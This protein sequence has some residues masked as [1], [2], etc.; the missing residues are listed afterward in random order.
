[1]IY[2]V[3]GMHK[4]GTTLVSQI[5]H[6]SGINMGEFDENVHYDKGNKYE[7]ESSFQLDLDLLGTSSDKVLDLAGGEIPPLSDTQRQRMQAVI[8]EGAATGGDWGMKDPRMCLTYERWREE[9]P[10]HKIIFVFRD[11]AQVWPRYKWLG[12][13][14]YGTNFNRAYS[15]LHRWQEH[16]RN[17]SRFLL[18]GAQERV[19]LDYHELMVGDAE[20]GRLQHFVGR[21]LEDRRKK[22]LYRSKAG[23]DIFVRF[24]DSLLGKRT[25]C[26]TADTMQ[27]LWDLRAREI[28]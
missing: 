4:S 17:V 23:Q 18:D 10:P 2:I 8:A 5:L 22:E 19:V 21:P 13:R 16:N 20:F 6:H 26:S 14:K 25:G 27:E 1:M 12:K 7:R 11:P 9:L 15:Y 3:L 24:A 28:G